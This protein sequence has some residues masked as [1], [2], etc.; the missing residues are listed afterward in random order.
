MDTLLRITDHSTTGSN[1]RLTID[2]R[3][4]A[5]VTF[6]TR[7]I[8]HVRVFDIGGPQLDRTWSISPGP[9]V[10]DHTGFGPDD[11]LDHSPAPA[12]QGNSRDIGPIEDVEVTTT[13]A[14]SAAEIARHPEF[15]GVYADEPVDSPDP[16][17]KAFIVGTDSLRVII[18]DCPLRM[19]WQ[20]RTDGWVTVSEDRP[21][22]AYEIGSRTGR[23]AHHRVRNLDDR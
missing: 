14:D 16:D 6:V 8:A 7:A 22:G 11:L 18:R 5:S 20:R 15:S 3:W 17:E 23:V 21:T 19:T 1:I 10:T 13:V 4:C 2:D 9:D 12:W